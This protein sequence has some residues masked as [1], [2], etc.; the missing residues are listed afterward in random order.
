M[1]VQIRVLFVVLVVA[2]GGCVE[3]PL[4]A[5]A[6][7]AD[8]VLAAMDSG[9]YAVGDDWRAAR[10][11]AVASTRNSATPEEAL[12]PLRL[13]LA[14]AGRSH[15][16]L[17]RNAEAAPTP[18]QSPTMP[19]VT[20]D[21]RLAVVRVPELYGGD[22]TTAQEYAR[23]LIAGIK[24]AA[25]AGS[26]G[27]IVDLRGNTGGDMRPMLAGLTPL[28]PNGIVG[29]SQAR[30]GSRIPI[31]VTDGMVDIAQERAFAQVETAKF[32]GP[33]AVLLDAYTASSAEFAAIAFIGLEN[34]RSF[35]TRSMGYSTMNV[36]IPIDSYTLLLTV[37]IDVDRTGKAYPSGVAPDERVAGSVDTAAAAAAWIRARC[38]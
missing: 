36:T 33:V 15:S 4:P 30:D 24:E 26:C 3:K 38:P 19:T 32:P 35:G 1:T 28:L 18:A 34:E 13:A 21:G 2:L 9:L 10:A 31:S 37:G 5:G 27:W 7:F 17:S 20:R 11:Q 22:A 14:H 25:V 16:T 8:R 6:V 12:A 23:S 29:S